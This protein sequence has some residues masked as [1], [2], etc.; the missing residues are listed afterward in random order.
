MSFRQ[1]QSGYSLIEVMVAVLVMGIGLLGIAAMQMVALKNSHSSL[2]TSQAVIQIYAITD[3]MR[4]NREVA[5][6]GGYVL[7]KTCTTPTGGALAANDLSGWVA[8]LQATLGSGSC[9]TISFDAAS[10]IYTVAVTWDDSRASGMGEAGAVAS[11][12]SE[13]SLSIQV[14]I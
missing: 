5:L 12:D 9:G 7:A 6:A 13:R 10:S 14:R 8:S 3:A 4:A 11:G 1:Q 2:E